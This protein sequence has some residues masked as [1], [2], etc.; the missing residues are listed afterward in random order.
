[1]GVGAALGGALVGAGTAGGSL[2]RKFKN[3]NLTPDIPKS[4]MDDVIAPEKVDELTTKPSETASKPAEVAEI[5][6]NTRSTAYT[7]D[8]TKPRISEQE[9][10]KKL[11][12]AGYTPKEANTILSDSLPDKGL[13]MPGSP[14]KLGF[15]ETSV[16]Q[17]AEAFDST[18]APTVK[19][20]VAGETPVGTSAVGKNVNKG[21]G[22]KIYRGN[23]GELTPERQ[24]F[25]EKKGYTS[26][27]DEQGKPLGS[28]ADKG[29]GMS[30]RPTKTG[31]T[32]D[33]ITRNG[34]IPKDVY[35]NPEY[36]G[37]M[38][39]P[40]YRESYSAIQSMKG[41]PDAEI[42]IYRASPNNKLN[43]GDWV[44]LSKSY[45][46]QES[47]TEGVK[48]NAHKVK[49]KD[50]Q[51]AG[52]DIN[53]FGYFPSKS[54]LP[55]VGRDVGKG[56]VPTRPVKTVYETDEKL[57]QLIK[58]KNDIVDAYAAEIK[59][60]E[61]RGDLISRVIR[62]GG[63]SSSAYESMPKGVKRKSGM[64]ADKMA[65]VLG[66]EDE[67]KF[68][69]ALQQEVSKGKY[70]LKA[71]REEAISRLESGK[72]PYST[73]YK[74]AF[75][76]ENT[77]RGEL[78]AFP[79]DAKV[80]ENA[81]E[82]RGKSDLENLASTAPANDEVTEG[83]NLKPLAGDATSETGTSALGESVR[84]KALKEKLITRADNEFYDVPT[85]NKAN[86][87]Q[88]AE[89]ASN[90][91][92]NDIDEAIAIALGKKA[93]PENVLSQM[94]FNAVEE[95]SKRIGGNEGANLILKLSQSKQVY[96]L[97]KMGQEIR[98]AAE[99]DPHSPTNMINDLATTRAK[100]LERRGKNVTKIAQEDAKTIKAAT[101]RIP[102]ETWDSFIAGLTC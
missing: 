73:D 7:P 82:T 97:T 1:M 8:T 54:T 9:A 68:I 43:E 39:L 37:Q 40:T 99:R 6:P 15:N 14:K 48:V 63:I 61:S 100:A 29:Y 21:V 77:R 46:K 59:E 66:F 19:P 52:D 17:S 101:P 80:I 87:E 71:A 92:I 76:L 20:P 83:V 22:G 42:T 25:L 36:Y 96:N 12:D 31:A 62:E 90:L 32:A 69:A 88:Q 33:D 84:K 4:G 18:Q 78:S 44:T 98:A 30:H 74:K 89:Y 93:P 27:V 64:S 41:K 34:T 51:F 58:S 86:M 45:A 2:F 53:E 24:A 50:I 38:D 47:L 79:E 16:K 3:R 10:T 85:Y 94:V 81:P 5:A 35:T 70:S 23:A 67:D 28:G 91:V 49:A 55:Q 13:S 26:F 57:Q 75:D 11:Q 102:R 72:S 56:K 65:Q 60:V 95:H